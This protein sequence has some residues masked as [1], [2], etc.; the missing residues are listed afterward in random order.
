MKYITNGT[1]RR[2]ESNLNCAYDFK[3]KSSN[4]YQYGCEF[5]FYIDTTLYDFES[6]I[7]EITKEMHQLTSANILVDLTSLPKEKDNNECLQIKPDLSL[8]TNGIEI[9]VPIISE[10]GIVHFIKN[11]CPI[12]EK[13][14]YTNE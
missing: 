5:E 11:I 6:A 1:T 4:T 12:I 3:T 8:D 2:Y 14:G 13:Y 9:S 10:S 7:Q